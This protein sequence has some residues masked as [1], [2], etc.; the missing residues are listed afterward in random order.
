M[1]EDLIIQSLRAVCAER[2][3][4]QARCSHLERALLYACYRFDFAPVECTNA[5]D[6]A[7][8]CLEQT[9]EQQCRRDSFLPPFPGSLHDA[10]SSG[11]AEGDDE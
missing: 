2:D 7:E 5:E 6:Y 4:L 11:N 1:P 9:E 10:V 3:Q 8:Y